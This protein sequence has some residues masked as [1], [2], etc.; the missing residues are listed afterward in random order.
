MVAH[1]ESPDSFAVIGRHHW[2]EEQEGESIEISEQLPHPE[3][4]FSGDDY[5]GD[6][7][8]LFLERPVADGIPIVKLNSESS[9]PEID[10]TVT[11]LGWGDTDIDWLDF[12][13]SDVL[14]SAELRVESNQDCEESRGL[15]RGDPHWYMDH[16]TENMLCAEADGIDSCQTDSGEII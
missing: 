6:I 8:L 15:I 10:S 5:G 1:C 2:M 9:L 14:K 16:V 12:E 4:D 13:M 11:V 3:F 7:M